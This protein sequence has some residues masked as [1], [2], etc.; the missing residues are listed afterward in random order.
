MTLPAAAPARHAAES[1]AGGSPE[2]SPTRIIEVELT[3]ALPRLDHD[4]HY[5]RVFIL[6]RLYTEPIG[7]CVR[8]LPKEGIDP[9]ELA[10]VLWQE[11]NAFIAERFAAAGLAAPTVLTGDGLAAAPGEWPLLRRRAV[12]LADAP[13]ISV[14]VC[15]RDRPEQIKKCLNRLARQ[16]Y[17][18]YEV[19]VVDNA[20][21][22]DALR[23]VVEGSVV[24]GQTAGSVAF[25]YT[26][27]PRPGLSWARN[28]GIV[29]AK[30]D[31]IAFLDDDDEPDEHWLTGI[32]EG[33]AKSSRM[34]CVSGIVLPARLD[35]AVENLFE[36]IG[37]HSKGRG[38]TAETFTRNGSQS[39]LWPL[40]PFGVGANM[41][42]R[43]E[44]LDRIG[45]FDVALGAGTPTGGGEDTLAISLVMM[46]GYE[47]AY[48]P[49]ALMWHHHRQDMVSL[50]KQLSNYSIGLTAFY[51]GLLRARPTALLGLVKL[52]P[53]AAGYLRGGR[54]AA[55]ET[56]KE[57]PGELEAQLDRKPM[58]GMLKG[59]LL[60]GRSRRQQ[61]RVA[62]A[63]R[64]R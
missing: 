20:P 29:A 41:A 46:S 56:P 25:R 24:E 9:S 62:A 19:V 47:V 2:F 37:G 15:T 40:P 3:R 12:L 23:P 22:S 21:T 11:L 6:A 14:V 18:R 54:D 8:P 58:Q 44:A 55:E 33:F 60:Y 57:E 35:N 59:P 36:R 45:G 48:E 50:N 34:G 31:I 51:A 63:T 28:A 61:R 49:A 32:A 42:F 13:F 17:P 26:V 10:A 38:F 52:L 16:E 5:G 39:P 7:V 27:E 43:R 4:G 64:A 53:L 30:S 1:A